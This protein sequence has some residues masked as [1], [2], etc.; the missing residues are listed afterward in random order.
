MPDARTCVGHGEAA[1]QRLR[2]YVNQP[3]GVGFEEAESMRTHLDIA[4]LQGQS[5]VAEY[6][7]RV[8]AFSN[9]FS[10]SLFF[11]SFPT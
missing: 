9:V 8:A 7:L 5:S 10:V 6:P 11:V 2:L 3:S 1:P 4:L